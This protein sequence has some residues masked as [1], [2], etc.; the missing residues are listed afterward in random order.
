MIVVLLSAYF[1]LVVPINYWGAEAVAGVGLG[2]AHDAADCAHLRGRLVAVGGR[3]VPQSRFSS[4]VQTVLMAQA[5]SADAYAV[6]GALF[7]FPRAGVFDLQFDQSDMVE[8]GVGDDG[9]MG[10]GQSTVIRT[11]EGDPKRVDGYRVANLS[12]QWFR[13]TRTVQLQGQIEGSL[14]LTRRNGEWVLSGALR[15][16]LPYELREV[17]ILTPRG[18]AR[19]GSLGARETQ[20]LRDEPLFPSSGY[21][22]GR[23]DF[24]WG[25]P[26]LALS[27]EQLAQRLSR[28]AL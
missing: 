2:V 4:K 16:R 20:T 17:Q 8:V 13:Y 18:A 6:N 26:V 24:D 10:F 14:R 19:I 21:G 22:G 23:Y 25:V 9:G 11:V 27:A 5:G 12:F 15:N 3:F 7:F 28:A 1:M